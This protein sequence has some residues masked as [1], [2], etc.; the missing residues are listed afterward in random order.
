MP[1]SRVWRRNGLIKLFGL[2]A[3][4]QGSIPGL[5]RAGEFNRTV[6][7]LRDTHKKL[8]NLSVPA[9]SYDLVALHQRLSGNCNQLWCLALRTRDEDV[10]SKINSGQIVLDVRLKSSTDEWTSL[11]HTTARKRTMDEAT[12]LVRPSEKA[13]R[14]SDDN[15]RR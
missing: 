15:I 3:K 6:D 13:F 12:S 9:S 8:Q 10:I 14:K 7:R 2:I 5:L 1:L 11:G 4:E